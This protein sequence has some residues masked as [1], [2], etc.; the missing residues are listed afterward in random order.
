MCTQPCTIFDAFA[1][2]ENL[3]TNWQNTYSMR[4]LV[5]HA[6]LFKESAHYSQ[7]FRVRQRDVVIMSIVINAVIAVCVFGA[8]AEL[9]MVESHQLR[10]H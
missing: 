5:S 7:S 4:P 2:D 3:I 10:Q 8:C 9:L 1:L 6:H